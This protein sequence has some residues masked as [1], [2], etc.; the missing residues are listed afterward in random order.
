M[1]LHQR[2]TDHSGG[3]RELFLVAVRAFKVECSR[4]ICGDENESSTSAIDIQQSGIVDP[5]GPPFALPRA[6]RIAP[7]ELPAR[8]ERPSLAIDLKV[9]NPAANVEDHCCG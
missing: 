6:G 7:P 5:S 4:R 9:L 1:T 2:A 8:G 3:R